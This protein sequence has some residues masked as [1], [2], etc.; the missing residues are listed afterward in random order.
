MEKGKFPRTPNHEHRNNHNAISTPIHW[1][2]HPRSISCLLLSLPACGHRNLRLR[3]PSLHS[4]RSMDTNIGIGHFIE[5]L[6]QTANTHNQR[7]QLSRRENI[8]NIPNPIPSNYTLDSKDRNDQDNNTKRRSPFRHL[9]G[10]DLLKNLAL[11]LLSC[12]QF[13]V[14]AQWRSPP[15][16]R[17][18]VPNGVSEEYSED[19]RKHY[20]DVLVCGAEPI[21]EVSLDECEALGTTGGRFHVVYA[22]PPEPCGVAGNGEVDEETDDTTPSRFVPL[23]FMSCV[24]GD[25]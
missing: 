4:A 14:F 5:H 22:H 10:G 25:C 6:D 24:I 8:A 1:G 23:G 20:G 2:S 12:R 7:D 11:G 21:P 18:K 9:A 3:P 15:E 19:H 17:P 16:F 13:P